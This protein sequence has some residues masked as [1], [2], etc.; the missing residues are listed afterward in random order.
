[1]KTVAVALA[2]TTALAGALIGY[3]V[4]QRAEAHNA[5]MSKVDSHA[6]ATDVNRSHLGD[7]ASRVP[8]GRGRSPS[9]EPKSLDLPRMG[10]LDRRLVNGESRLNGVRIKTLTS[11]NKLITENCRHLHRKGDTEIEMDVQVAITEGVFSVL[12]VANIGVRRGAPLD[13]PTVSCITRLFATAIEIAGPKAAVTVLPGL[14][15][16]PTRRWY[17]MEGTA[18]TIVATARLS[19]QPDCTVQSAAGEPGARPPTR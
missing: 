15:G 2:T 14:I 6:G 12:G 5:E 17:G 16:A 18:G 4:G 7:G 13:E 11:V 1:V 9:M 19:D 3:R 10:S 8:E